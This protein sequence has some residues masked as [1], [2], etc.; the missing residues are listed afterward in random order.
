VS[1]I[2]LNIVAL[3]DF[4]SV[5]DAIAKL[6]ANVASL[7]ASLAGATGASF[8]KAAASVKGL[9]NEFAS[10]LTNSGAFTKQ[11][12]SLQSE[13]EKFGQ[14]LQK[15]TLGLGSYYQILTKQQGAATN[16]V[17]ALAL[18]QTKLQNSIVMSDPTK[19]G[20]Y[21]VLTPKSINAVANATKI[22]ANEQN[23]YNVA[24]RAGSNEL[25]NWGKNTQ[26]AGRQ[27]TVGMAIPLLVFGQQAVSAFD[28]VNTA[29]TQLQKVYGEG[30]IP[31]SQDSINQISQEVLNLGK[32]MAQTLGISQEFTVQVA[33]QFAAMGKTGNDL[34]TITQQT[35]RL[36]KLGNLDQATATNAVIALQNV[37]KLNTT[38]LADAVNYFGSMQKQTSLSMSDLVQSESRVGPIIEE[39][40]GTYKDS[41]V[42]ILAMKEAGVP[43]AKSANALK[44]AMASIINPTSAATKEFAS[45]GINLNNIKDQK[46]PVNMILALQEALKPLSKMQQEQLIDKLFGKYQF[47]NI[48][49]L[50]Q[51]LGTAG[52]QTVNALQVANATSGQLATLANQE[53]KQVTSS[54]S[55]Q[56]QKALATFKADLYPIG[57]DIIKIGTKVLEFGNKISSVFQGLPGPVKFFL[58]LLA[59]LTVLAGPIIMLTG[60]MANFV[61]NILKGV[62]NFKDLIS[63]GKSMRQLFTPEIIAAQNATNLF[64]DGLKGD[65]DQIQ[66]LTQAIADLTAKLS[67][68]KDQMSVGAGLNELKSAVGATA[69]VE[70]SIFEQM[71]LPGFAK[72]GIIR[73]SGTGTSDSILA[74]VSNGETILTEEQTRKNAGVIVDII[75]GKHIQGYSEGGQVGISGEETMSRAWGSAK[76]RDT[77]SEQLEAEIKS[78][79][80]EKLAAIKAAKGKLLKSDM[81]AVYDAPITAEDLGDR[82]AL[83]A[84]FAEQKA[85]SE[86]AGGG[87]KMTM[88][89]V[90]STKYAQEKLGGQFSHLG[91]SAG[92]RQDISLIDPNSI[93]DEKARKDLIAMQKLSAERENPLHASV[94]SGLGY[95]FTGTANSGMGKGGGANAE[96]FLSEFEGRSVEKWK[97]S[98]ALAGA[99]LDKMPKDIKDAL[100]KWDQ[101]IVANLKSKL[102]ETGKTTITDEDVK[103][104]EAKA[105]ASLSKSADKASQAALGIINTADNIITEVRVKVDNYQDSLDIDEATGVPHAAYSTPPQDGKKA[106]GPGI[107]R[108][109]G[110]A[111]DAFRKGQVGGMGMVNVPVE[112]GTPSDGNIDSWRQKILQR[113]KKAWGIASP[114]SV[115]NEEIGQPIG[116]GV[117]QGV[118]KTSEEITSSIVSPVEAAKAEIQDMQMEL[119]L[120][121]FQTPEL[122]PQVGPMM[123]NGGFYSNEIAPGISGTAEKAANADAEA[124]SKLAKAKQS[125]LGKIQKED[126]TLKTSVRS[127]LG[128]GLLMAG[129]QVS[130]MLPKGSLASSAAGNVSTYAGMGMMIGPEGAA[131]G[132]AAGLLVTAFTALSAAS[133]EESNS[134]KASFSLSSQAAQQFGIN[135]TPLS[136]YD[137]ASTS[138]GLSEHLA[139]IKENKAAVDS[140]TQ[141]YLSA[142]DQMTTDYINKI[143]K[144]TPDQLQFDMNSKYASNIQGGLTS[145]QAQQDV[146]AI[147]KAAGTSALTIATI[148]QKLAKPSDA[149]AAFQAN[150]NS[151][152]LTFDPKLNQ[153]ITPLQ[154]AIR[155]SGPK[156]AALSWSNAGR[157]STANAISGSTTG[158]KGF[159]QADSVVTGLITTLNTLS[160]GGIKQVDIAMKGLQTTA[161][162]ASAATINTDQVYQAFSKSLDQSS[163]GFKKYADQLRSQKGTTMDLVEAT[164]LLTSGQVKLKDMQDAMVKGGPALEALFAKYK[165]VI[166]TA[167]AAANPKPTSTPPPT[168][169]STKKIFTGTTAEQ[170]MEKLLAANLGQQNAQLKIVK[171]Q[172]A[173]QQKIVTAVKQQM[174][175]QQQI[176]GLQNDMKTAMI[177]GNYLQAATLKQQISGA[178]VDFNATSVSQKL[179]DQ[180]D[181][182][183]TNADAINTALSDL[184]DAIANNVTE[185]SSSVTAASKLKTIGAKTVS[186]GIGLGAPT[187]TTVINVTGTVDSTST[188]SNHPA[189]KPIIKGNGVKPMASKVV[190]G[191][192]THK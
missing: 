183:Q 71:A 13:T 70:T 151:A 31:P 138:S 11:T 9:S 40:G 128:M 20:F 132:A 192:G 137:F 143:K 190:A 79:Y 101:D 88:R 104:A 127:G 179:Q 108:I 57:Q 185:I 54:P 83:Q 109:G 38:Q 134:L 113:A 182:M 73:G 74:R 115:A 188:T 12:V 187:V 124:T 97:K 177:S 165:D 84:R 6:K 47:G 117:I 59:G 130:S 55:A 44:S 64:A 172:L 21:S 140:L 110:Y 164:S 90:Q 173:E 72:G 154:Q 30:L 116:Q 34:L 60:L 58:G 17:K 75:T 80:E 68:M 7:N 27:L 181:T 166:A 98:F 85:K 155:N 175:Y 4:T 51:N 92:G 168:H 25:I 19:S 136:N 26:W 82:P 77:L 107:A 52:S 61:G 14:S 87:Y 91:N 163:P 49:A 37:Y 8:D 56:W 129:Q 145:D 29:L 150:V 123:A 43:A 146:N 114:S 153:A 62:I 105:R 89:G 10:A 133:R 81:K 46:G 147:M 161:G 184:K 78:Y 139:S 144:D 96:K 41:A 3:G 36:A 48:T 118:D 63:G 32:S 125:L 35:D 100:T 126:G 86:A 53:I 131:V 152:Q 39:L 106:Q 76:T 169:T 122:T 99:P 16:S 135:F 120:T 65:V 141:A 157:A 42:M 121:S 162:Q 142:T 176:N 93:A 171:T 66:L 180:A 18:E 148:N 178:K 24:L 95:E 1:N 186:S 50:I 149:A 33:T 69:Q 103:E 94:H 111:S 28:S 159:Q 23:I 112:L 45:F 22:A 174:Q 15:G 167:Q 5:N 102:E 160:Q 67:I 2:E 119:P 170:A 158:T 189:V 156:G 191:K